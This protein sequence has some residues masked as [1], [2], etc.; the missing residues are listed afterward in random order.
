MCHF[1]YMYRTKYNTKFS[2]LTLAIEQEPENFLLQRLSKGDHP[3]KIYNELKK[4]STK[5]KLPLIERRT[6]Y[7]WIAKI[8]NSYVIP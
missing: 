5:H 7:L 4:I 2:Q 1:N 8:K 3:M 6:L